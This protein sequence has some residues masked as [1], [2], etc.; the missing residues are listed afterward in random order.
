MLR[1]GPVLVVLLGPGDGHDGSC[2]EVRRPRPRAE[3]QAPTV[4]SASGS[5]SMSVP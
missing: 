1:D 3:R 4:L 5:D 2:L